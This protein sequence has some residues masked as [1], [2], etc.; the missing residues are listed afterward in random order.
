MP[1]SPFLRQVLNPAIA[2]ACPHHQSPRTQTG[3]GQPAS[4]RCDSAG[5]K[6]VHQRRY[7]VRFAALGDVAIAAHCGADADRSYKINI[8]NSNCCRSA[9]APLFAQDASRQIHLGNQPA[10]EDITIGVSV[11]RHHQG[12]QCQL[13]NW[14]WSS[15]FLF[16]HRRTQLLIDN[17]RQP[18]C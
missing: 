13:A 17:R 16:I 9:F 10:T 1:T 3:H 4:Y 6:Y 14:F 18:G 2:V 7:V 8:L 5:V 12:L 11:S 15:D